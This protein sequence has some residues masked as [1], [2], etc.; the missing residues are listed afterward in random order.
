MEKNTKKMNLA[1]VGGG[2]TGI[3]AAYELAKTS[4]FKVTVF[5]KEKNLGG[6]SSSYQWNGVVCDRFYHVILP[7]DIN[8]LDFIKDLGIEGD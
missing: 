5:E 1:V 4:K 6:L 7:R 8:T 3:A 2:I